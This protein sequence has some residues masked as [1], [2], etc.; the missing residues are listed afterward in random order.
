MKEEMKQN[1]EE[2]AIRKN[3][4]SKSFLR[5]GYFLAGVSLLTFVTAY[6]TD[7]SL[8]GYCYAL[9][10]IVPSIQLF[11]SKGERDM[12][13]EETTNPKKTLFAIILTFILAA[14]ICCLLYQF[15]RDECIWGIM[16]IISAFLFGVFTTFVGN[17]QQDRLVS[18]IGYSGG[19]VIGC[20]VF[21]TLVESNQIPTFSSRE[22]MLIS[23]SLF[24]VALI[25]MILPGHIM[26]QRSI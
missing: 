13:K 18:S 10:F 16:P 7:S 6:I 11:M 22:C 21:V 25:T 3:A 1:V 17:L 24:F 15:L 19:I 20:I 26:S 14:T 5:L 12:Q 2:Q 9:L 23:S 4:D 8:A